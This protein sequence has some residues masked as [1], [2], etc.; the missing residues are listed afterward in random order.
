MNP[1][2]E[3]MTLHNVGIEEYCL[4]TMA[5]I[6][7]VR[8]FRANGEQPEDRPRTPI[9][10]RMESCCNHLGIP[11][12]DF[13]RIVQ[14]YAER[15]ELAHSRPPKAGLFADS[16]NITVN[17]VEIKSQCMNK[18]IELNLAYQQGRLSTDQ[19]HL[20]KKIVK[21]WFRVY[22]D[23]FHVDGSPNLTDAGEKA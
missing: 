17:W 6:D 16:I 12:V 8:H 22:V 4:A 2:A 10:V 23:G 7:A 5:E 20:D 3:W 21:L 15:N 9:L 19:L 13:I 1:T 18:N 11:V 14:H